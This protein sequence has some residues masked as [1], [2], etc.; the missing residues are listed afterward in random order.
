MVV[1]LLLL[2]LLLLTMMLLMTMMTAMLQ[3]QWTI[4]RETV[5]IQDRWMVI[6]CLNDIMRV[7]EGICQRIRKIG[8]LRLEIAHL[9]GNASKGLI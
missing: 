9:N 8:V 4:C 2:L 1:M 3:Y 6:H 5:L 7:L